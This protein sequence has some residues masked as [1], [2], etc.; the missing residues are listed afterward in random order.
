MLSWRAS[1]LA[2]STVKGYGSH[3]PDSFFQWAHEN[4]PR[5]MQA[6]MHKHGMERDPRG[7]EPLYRE[8]VSTM[9]DRDPD[10]ILNA[11]FGSGLSAKR[12]DGKVILV[13]PNGG[14]M[15]FEA[16]VR[17]GLSTVTGA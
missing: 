4:K 12:V 8:Y 7:Y 13:L 10:A 2:V 17:S 15:G 5:E 16:A 6:A 11:T 3:D 1:G 9:A 14:E